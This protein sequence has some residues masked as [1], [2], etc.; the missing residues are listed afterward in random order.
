MCKILHYFFLFFIW[1]FALFSVLNAAQ[2]DFN[3]NFIKSAESA[4]PAVVNI[5]IYKD[6]ENNKV[7]S[8]Y[9]NGFGSGTIISGKGYI[10]TNCHVLRKGSFYK[11]I[12][13]DGKECQAITFPNGKY[14]LADEKSDIALL[15]ID[16]NEITHIKP[17]QFD[18]SNELSEGEWVLAIGNPYGLRQSVTCG[19]VS[20]K[21]RSDIGFADIEDFIQTD[22]SINPGNSGGPLINLNGKL[23]GINTAIRTKSGGYQGI[24]FA[25]PSNIVKQVSQELL[26]YGRVRRGWL[27]FLSQERVMAEGGERKVLEIISVIKNSP[28]EMCGIKKGDIIKEI[29]GK[30]MN[31][32]GELI[33]SVSHKPIGSEI[34]ISLSRDGKISEYSLVLREKDIYN[35]LQNALE[36]IYSAYG[37]D[38]DKNSI[39]GDILISYLSPMGPAY[40]AG[41]K[42]GDII[43]SINGTP[44]ASLEEFVKIYNKEKNKIFQLEILRAPYQY[45]VTLTGE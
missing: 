37:I 6:S 13:F 18:D 7:R 27:G 28:A 5:I 40:Q 34:K 45:T 14:Y 16:E 17:L 22:V 8:L 25:I 26:K 38:L 15:R 41:L 24:S 1:C 23:V 21:G 32:L 30:I 44:V 43:I 4:K 2:P 19:I 12:L 9:K 42:K 20:S 3:K 11:I 35:K 36:N 33:N 29:D 39:T 10:V 31:T